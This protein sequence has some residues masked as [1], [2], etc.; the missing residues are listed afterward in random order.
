MTNSPSE[1]AV[2]Q[3]A[4]VS[5]VRESPLANVKLTLV[6]SLDEALAL[7]RW[8]GERRDTPLGV[9]S[10]SEGLDPARHDLRL[11]QVG[12]MHQGFAIPW[13]IWGGLAQEVISGYEGDFVAH[14][15]SFDWRFL[16]K[17][18]NITIPWSKLHDT[19]TLAT[20]DD[21]TRLRGLKPLT[22]MLI[23][24]QATAGERA[25]HEGMRN[26]KWTWATVPLN[27]PAYWCVPLTTEILTKRGWRKWNELCPEDQTLGYFKG[28]LHWTSITETKVFKDQP[29]VRFGNYY[30]NT[31]ATENHR[32]LA[33]PRNKTRQPTM[34]PE[35]GWLPATGRRQKLGSIKHPTKSVSIHRV[36]A[37][38]YKPPKDHLDGFGEPEFMTT[39]QAWLEEDAQ[40]Q[41]TGY[42]MGGQSSCTPDEARI[43]AWILSDG[44]IWKD[45][46]RPNAVNASITQSRKKFHKEIKDLLER[47]D[48]Y[49][50]AYWRESTEC[51][52]FHVKAAYARRL[53]NSYGL[54]DLTAFVLSLTNESRKAWA[55]VWYMAEGTY[56]GARG[57][58]IIRKSRSLAQNLGQKLD[59]IALTFFLE[60]HLPLI[61]SKN[62]K[63]PPKCMNMTVG[64][65][66]IGNSKNTH[67]KIYEDAGRCDVWCPTTELGTWV[68]R[69]NNGRIF[70]T[71]NSYSALDPTLTT[72]L[73]NHLYPRVM[74]DCPD[75]YAL[76]RGVT[77]VC[78][79]M[80]LKGI[81]VDR[82]YIEENITKLK[83]YSQESREWLESAHGIKNPLSSRQIS[84]AME[85]CGYEIPEKT[86]TGLPRVDKEVLTAIRDGY[87]EARHTEDGKH[88]L[89]G[90]RRSSPT[91]ERDCPGVPEEA[92]EI[93]RFVLGVRHIDKVVGSYL[94]NFLNTADS[95]DLIHPSIHPLQART[96]RM[97]ITD[98]ALQT[99]HRDDKVVRGCF[100]PREGHVFISCDADQIELRVA[101]HLSS[102]SGLIEAFH[103]ADKPGGLDFFS[104][105]A[106]QLFNDKVRK[107]DP[108]RQVTKNMAYCYIFGGGLDKMALTAGVPVD[109]M[110]PIREA[111]MKRF[112]GLD[113]L[114]R[115][116]ESEARTAFRTTG[117]AFIRTPTGRRLPV[118][119]ERIY[120]GLNFKIQ[121]FAAEIL[122]KGGLDLDATGLG[123]NLLL[124]IHDE[125]LLEVPAGEAEDAVKT[126]ENTLT[127]RDSYR[128]PLTWGAAVMPNR[129]IKTD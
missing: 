62:N 89:A 26:N 79:K 119:E 41:L 74:A 108:R 121:G 85:K 65:T 99:L 118:D 103:E 83:K 77:R 13:P 23:D 114:A 101:A 35:C 38:G 16:H 76:E 28:E 46:A 106:S 52:V 122:K 37:H 48:A 95:E 49:T 81:K 75:V 93:A 53:W 105:V 47:E 44:S 6:D 87:V 18:A 123:D 102:D 129:W 45:R 11:I 33:R 112:P 70:V 64:K 17:R 72:H 58:K 27:F 109:Q 98:P 92:K 84:A 59:A 54:E 68:A 51:Y 61:T 57:A 15:A 69:D 25:L 88:P 126:I 67:R 10:E 90:T 82:V 1:A 21:P 120:A 78:A 14:N 128:V 9:D 19:M 94:E 96:G 111:F 8:L 30:W 20:L 39:R 29:V 5:H 63:L 80:M 117:R 97:S 100:V 40:L 91:S 42:A 22:S 60:G 113:K 36:R 34:C 4:A 2:P 3:R 73:W 124:F 127:D 12:D 66:P 110:R 125:V 32:W 31:V 86:K 55:E 56:S 116:T 50:K 71:A 7:K 115:R 107:G 43:L 24:K 104:S